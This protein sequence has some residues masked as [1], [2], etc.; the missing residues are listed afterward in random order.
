MNPLTDA[1]QTFVFA[2]EVCHIAF[3]HIFRSEKKDKKIW[4]KATD[5]IIN[6]YLKEDGMSLVKGCVD[7][8]E[9]INYD[10]E[11]MYIK[12]LKEKNKEKDRK[13]EFLIKIHV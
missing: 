1:E 13:M 7:I 3:N 2:H 8:E 12:L 10:A 11:E 5:A 4:N 6:A 9:A